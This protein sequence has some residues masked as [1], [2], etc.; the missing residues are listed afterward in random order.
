MAGDAHATSSAST[1]SSTGGSLERG[2][3]RRVQERRR[4][5][6][7]ELQ[8]QKEVD[9]AAM[10]KLTETAMAPRVQPTRGGE[11]GAARREGAGGESVVDPLTQSEG[12]KGGILDPPPPPPLPTRGAV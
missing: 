5:A 3:G 2:C 6:R 11:A 8:R 7:M 9:E 4:A 10:A 1:P 12:T